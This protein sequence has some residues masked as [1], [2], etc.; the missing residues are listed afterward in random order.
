MVIRIFPRLT[1]G[2]GKNAYDHFH[3]PNVS[4]TGT[5]NL[6][7]RSKPGGLNFSVKDKWGVKCGQNRSNAVTFG[8][9]RS[10]KIARLLI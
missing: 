2:S 5:Q 7:S 10:L 8:L 6:V 4:V 9:K 1:V 3:G